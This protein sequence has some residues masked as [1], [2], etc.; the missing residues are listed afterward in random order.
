MT[1]PQCGRQVVFFDEAVDTDADPIAVRDEFPCPGCHVRLTKR[2]L[3]PFRETVHDPLLKQNHPAGQAGARPS[4]VPGRYPA[5]DE[6]SRRRRSGPARLGR[7]RRRPEHPGA[8]RSEL[9]SGSLSEGNPPSGMTHLHHYYTPR[10]F[11]TLSRMIA[12]AGGPASAATDQ[13][14]PVDLGAALLVPDH[15]PARQAGQRADDRHPPRRLAARRS[16]PDQEPSKASSGT[17]PGSTGRCRQ[18]NYVGCGS[19]S[20]LASIP[21][22]S[23]DYVFIDPPFGDN[24]N[25]SPVEPALGGLVAGADERGVGSHRGPGDEP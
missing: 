22:A 18:C 19:S 13:P 11:L 15:L 21:D 25:Y 23:I 5:P 9:T 1:C 20:R 6:A 4:Q 16:Q 14:D 2:S 24:L 3:E 10:N 7:S 8:I 17:S 12:A